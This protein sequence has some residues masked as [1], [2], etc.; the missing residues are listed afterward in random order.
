[1]DVTTTE[2]FSGHS[3]RKQLMAYAAALKPRPSRIVMCHGDEKKCIEL[4][5]AIHKNLNIE[6]KAP[7]NLESI[8][9][10]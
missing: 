8:R 2:G 1:M 4:S 3:D 7:F 6:T 9:Y 10:R 5:E